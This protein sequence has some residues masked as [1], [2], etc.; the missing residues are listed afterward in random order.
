MAWAA[1]DCG[2]SECLVNL[3]ASGRVAA[4]G[5]VVGHGAT[6]GV[7]GP[8]PASVDLRS[9]SNKASSGESSSTVGYFLA[10]SVVGTSRQAPEWAVR[11]GADTRLYQRKRS[12]PEAAGKP[13]SH[14]RRKPLPYWARRSLYPLSRDARK[15]GFNGQGLGSACPPR[16]LSPSSEH[17][18]AAPSFSESARCG[19]R[20]SFR[21]ALAQAHVLSSR[22]T[23]QVLNHTNGEHLAK[24]RAAWKCAVKERHQARRGE[25]VLGVL[26]AGLPLLG[27]WSPMEK[28]WR[29]CSP[30]AHSTPSPLAPTRRRAHISRG[31]EGRATKTGGSL[32]VG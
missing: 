30:H 22:H 24:S 13:V 11:K 31:Q 20:L 16:A 8:E 28:R 1:L 7:D 10:A 21:A 3:A 9:G 19:S 14:S 5:R 2:Q 32:H 6:E 29:I 27:C 26:H 17:P 15:C 23:L 18:D 12:S 4:E 25:R